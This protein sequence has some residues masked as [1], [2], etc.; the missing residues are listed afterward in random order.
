MGPLPRRN[1]REDSRGHACWHAAPP[2]IV[3]VVR[4]ASTTHRL[5]S[6][7]RHGSDGPRRD[8]CPAG[9]SRPCG[10]CHGTQGQAVVTAAAAIS[11][12]G[13]R[14]AAVRHARR[15]SGQVSALA[16]MIGGSQPFPRVAQQI[17]AARGSLDSLLVRLI[18]LELRDCI[19]GRE[20]RD[21]V[22]G[23]LRTALGRAAGARSGSRAGHGRADTHAH[24]HPEGETRL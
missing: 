12:A 24:E 22:D 20:A 6:L 11:T 14:R 2:V 8:Q 19:P 7:P 17:L 1:P 9:L 16:A 21:E 3:A 15:A 10:A 4:V 13:D 5:P 23:L 18:E